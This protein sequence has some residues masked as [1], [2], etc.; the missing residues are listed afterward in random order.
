MIEVDKLCSTYELN[1]NHCQGEWIEKE[2]VDFCFFTESRKIRA[3]ATTSVRLGQ[4][5]C[6]SSTAPIYTRLEEYPVLGTYCIVVEGILSH[7]SPL[8]LDS[9]SIRS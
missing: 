8:P 4:Q 9:R 7:T 6:R 5:M 3:C 1:S 2:L